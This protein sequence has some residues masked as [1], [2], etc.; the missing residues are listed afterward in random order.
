M[1]IVS[2]G[3]YQKN[4]TKKRRCKSAKARE[5]PEQRGGLL[6]TLRKPDVL[7]LNMCEKDEGAR[8]GVGIEARRRAWRAVT[9][10]HTHLH[11]C[12]TH[13][14]AKNRTNKMFFFLLV[15]CADEE[16]EETKLLTGELKKKTQKIVIL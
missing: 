10:K 14:H 15:Y 16:D 13:T 3:T 8:K 4:K 1:F 2:K 7:T 6:E 11:N 5:D 12:R 9:D